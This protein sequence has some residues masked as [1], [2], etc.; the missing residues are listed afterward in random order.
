[1]IT[2]G[3]ISGERLLHMQVYLGCL[4]VKVTIHTHNNVHV[5]MFD[6]YSS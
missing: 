3:G 5:E 2:T 1:M 6:F 4:L